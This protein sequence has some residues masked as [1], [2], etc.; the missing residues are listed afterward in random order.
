VRPSSWVTINEVRVVHP[1]ELRLTTSV[2][3]GPTAKSATSSCCFE[4]ESGIDLEYSGTLEPIAYPDNS[5]VHWDG[6]DELGVWHF[7]VTTLMIDP[8]TP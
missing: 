2:E 4:F 3:S 6:D 7:V 1:P 8:F 5:L